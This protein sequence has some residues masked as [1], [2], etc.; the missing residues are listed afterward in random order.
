MGRQVFALLLCGLLL[1]TCLQVGAEEPQKGSLIIE[2]PYG[3]VEF[4][5]FLVAKGTD[6]GEIVA[7]GDFASYPLHWEGN[8]REL[9]LTLQGYIIRDNIQPLAL[10]ATNGSGYIRFDHLE[11]GYYLIIG[12]HLLEEDLV[13]FPQPTMVMMPLLQGEEACYR[14]QVKPKYERRVLS[15]SMELHVLK[16]WDDNNDPARP[17]DVIVDLLCDE[18]IWD[19]V[20]LSG[21]N[22]WRHS[23]SDLPSMHLWTVVE[24]DSGDYIVE[25][26]REESRLVITNYKPEVLYPTEPTETT[27][28]TEPVPPP[29]IPQTGMLWW[30]VPVLLLAGMALI[31]WGWLCCRRGREE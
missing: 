12:N 1:L 10:A 26:S 2:Y 25:V 20:V 29:D 8:P 5:L 23:W 13:T 21:D 16:V 15:N 3:G 22:N 4:E 19:T 27:G 28:P 14:V 6:K 11:E 17:K 24:R 9:A 30:P 7:V 31:F 18:Q